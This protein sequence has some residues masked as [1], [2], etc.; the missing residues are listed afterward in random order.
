MSIFKYFETDHKKKKKTAL[1]KGINDIWA[2]RKKIVIFKGFFFFK[3]SKWQI[4]LFLPLAETKLLHM[5]FWASLQ[6][7]SSRDFRW[8]SFYSKRLPLHLLILFLF[9]ERRRKRRSH[10]NRGRKSYKYMSL[11]QYFRKKSN[12]L[13]QWLS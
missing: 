4:L 12:Y 3:I 10:F 8:G 9:I 6:C 2:F 13:K 7:S 1:G 5:S 11:N